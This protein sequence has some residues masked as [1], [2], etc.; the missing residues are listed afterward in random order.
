MNDLLNIKKETRTTYPKH[1][2]S[3]VHCEIQFS[4]NFSGSLFNQETLLKDSL[5]TNGDFSSS[6]PIIQGQFSFENPENSPPSISQNQKTVGIMF[7]NQT[8]KRELHIFHDKI[9]YSESLYQGFAEFLKSLFKNI[10][11]LISG[12]NL[13]NTDVLKVGLRKINAITIDEVDHLPD[14]LGIFN[15]SLFGLARSGIAAHKDISA[16]EEALVINKDQANCILRT[17]LQ[18]LQDKKFAANLDFDLI[19]TTPTSLEIIQKSVLPEL[20]DLHFSIFRWAVTN[21]LIKL[22]EEV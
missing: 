17:S 10:D 19:N 7:L 14:A 5:I 2:L 1:F 18:N 22:M 11:T 21:E 15:S 3:S 6:R 13:A 9:I 20:N 16:Y 8:E 4:S 12:L